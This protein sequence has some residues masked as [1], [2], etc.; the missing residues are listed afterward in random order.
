M[1][2]LRKTVR[3]VTLIELLIV[4]DI[5]AIWAAMLLPALNKARESGKKAK[6][7]NNMKTC[8]LAHSMYMNDY[9]DWTVG[10]SCYHNNDSWDC[11]LNPYLGQLQRNTHASALLNCPSNPFGT[12]NT[13][14]RFL[15]GYGVNAYIATQDQPWTFGIEGRRGDKIGRMRSPGK[16]IWLAERVQ[17]NNCIFDQSCRDV[18]PSG[19]N[20]ARNLSVHAGRKNY[21]FYDGHIASF[22][23]QGTMGESS[24]FNKPLGF[25]I[26]Q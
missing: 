25:W 18:A 8:G 14:G 23:L 16:T 4:I 22:T 3:K 9:N 1:Q 26:G 17:D 19:I 24:D 11:A 2:N 13:A 15:R 7:A 10:A 6:C 21:G 5:I 20:D 12:I